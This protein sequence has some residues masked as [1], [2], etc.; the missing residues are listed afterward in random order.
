VQAT[1]LAVRPPSTTTP[2]EPGGSPRPGRPGW[3]PRCRACHR[4]GRSPRPATASDMSVRACVTG[5]RLVVE[6]HQS[7]AAGAEM[8]RRECFRFA[9]SRIEGPRMARQSVSSARTRHAGRQPD[10]AT[11]NGR[12]GRCRSGRSTATVRT[13]AA[14]GDPPR[15]PPWRHAASEPPGPSRCRTAPRSAPWTPTSARHP[16]PVELGHIGLLVA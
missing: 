1:G 11:C 2:V 15:C 8:P 7:A 5:E 10:P 4:C 9:R 14:A 12:P 13:A 3:W 16:A 6:F